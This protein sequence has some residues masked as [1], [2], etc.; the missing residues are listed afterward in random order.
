M[1]VHFMGN[2]RNTDDD[3]DEYENYADK[4]NHDFSTLNQVFYKFSNQ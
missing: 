3:Y 2:K 1:S 4:N